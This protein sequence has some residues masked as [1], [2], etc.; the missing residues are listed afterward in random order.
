MRS[1]RVT[2]HALPLPAAVVGLGSLVSEFQPASELRKK[3]LTLPETTIILEGKLHPAFSFTL[4]YL[5]T[6][7]V[8]N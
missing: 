4:V 1:M 5:L 2:L 3:F 6:G 8:M 7:Q